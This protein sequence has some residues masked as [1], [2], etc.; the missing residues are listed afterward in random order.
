MPTIES[1]LSINEARELRER[2]EAERRTLLTEY[3]LDLE[4]ERA[5][6]TDETGDLVDRAEVEWDRRAL[7]TSAEDELGRLRQISDA[8]RRMS[9]GSYGVCLA[10]GE[11]IPLERLRAVPWTRFC[12]AHQGEWEARQRAAAERPRRGLHESPPARV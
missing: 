6:P 9:D 5:I 3:E 10:D 2:L 11:P 8:L 7:L 1:R 12:A 4:R